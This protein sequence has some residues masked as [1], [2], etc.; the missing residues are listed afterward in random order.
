MCL[1]WVIPEELVELSHTRPGGR[2]YSGRLCF[3]SPRTVQL[4][5]PRPIP[6]TQVLLPQEQSMP[7]S[8]LPRTWRPESLRAKFPRPWT[9]GSPSISELGTAFLLGH[10]SDDRPR[11]TSYAPPANRLDGPNQTGLLFISQEDRYTA[12]NISTVCGW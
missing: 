12:K 4:R 2:A 5:V 6:Q 7:A 3:E 11:V 9:G 10:P 1:L 8:V